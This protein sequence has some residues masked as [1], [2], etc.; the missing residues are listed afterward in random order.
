MPAAPP[1]S[2]EVESRWLEL[3]AGEVTR[4]RWH[5]WAAPLR[6]ADNSD[7]LMPAPLA[8]S[9]LQ[10]LHG[11][12]ALPPAGPECSDAASCLFLHPLAIR[13]M[14]LPSSWPEPAATRPRIRATEATE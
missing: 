11:F 2:E 8:M 14:H 6:L 9:G 12:T 4:E 10:Y 1:I 7:S 3:I 5:D 13:T